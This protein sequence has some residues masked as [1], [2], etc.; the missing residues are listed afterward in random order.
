MKWITKD[1]DVYLQAREY[2]DT[3]VMPLIPISWSQNV[4]STVA[5]GE[6]ITILSAEIERQFKGRVVLFPSFTYSMKEV[7]DNR[8]D[9]MQ[10]MSAEIMEG[11]LKHII[12]ITSDSEWKQVEQ[13]L[14][15]D[16]LWIPSLPLEYVEEKYKQKMIQDQ[17][18]Q[19]VSIFMDIWQGK[20]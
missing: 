3:A 7:M 10:A 11:G 8:L 2:V 13:N 17:M 18:K 19:L 20:K 4:K 5:L 14:P 6:F 12:Y 9:R 1:I 16:L 15:G